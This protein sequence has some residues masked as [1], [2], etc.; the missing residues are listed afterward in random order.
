MICLDCKGSK[1]YFGFHV[2][3]P[4]K[5]CGGSGT[6]A[7]SGAIALNFGAERIQKFEQPELVMFD[8]AS[9][10]GPNHASLKHGEIKYVYLNQYE[11]AVGNWVSID[12]ETAA[13]MDVKHFF[14]R[15]S[16]VFYALYERVKIGEDIFRL[17]ESQS[18]QRC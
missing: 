13:E 17:I 8:F 18:V 7:S 10:L 9:C 15:H 4:C 3:E 2:R 1:F 14:F 11:G 6:A 12:R 5:A 16:S